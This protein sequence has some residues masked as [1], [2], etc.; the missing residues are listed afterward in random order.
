[1]GCLGPLGAEG[2]IH[3]LAHAVE[4]DEGELHVRGHRPGGVGVFGQA[5]LD[6]ALLVEVAA[7]HR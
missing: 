2:G 7:L 5:G 3:L 1:M 4:V 6:A